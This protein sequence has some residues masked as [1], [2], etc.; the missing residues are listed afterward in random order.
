VNAAEAH[1][2]WAPTYDRNP[3]AVLAL[4]ERVVEPR[5]PD[6][7][8]MQVLDVACGT[9]RWLA[10]LSRRGPG[11]ATGIDLS[12]EMLAQARRKPGVKGRLVEGDVQ[13]MP[14]GRASVD[15]AICSFALSY[16]RDVDC[17]AKELARVVKRQGHVIVTDFHPSAQARGWKRSFRHN[18]AIVEISS[19][20]RSVEQIRGVFEGQGFE[21][22]V[23]EE[24]SFGEEEREIFEKSGK[25]ALF[26]EVLGQPA[27][28]VGVLR[29]G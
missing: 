19:F 12:R 26:Q 2:L 18:D 15:F 27:L 5:L 22:A 23:W 16:V 24:P 8:G 28:Y 11:T 25:G 10:H 1:A 7:N 14:F 21:S 9:G 6:V 3:N 4:E 29:R 13:A 20:P 17:V